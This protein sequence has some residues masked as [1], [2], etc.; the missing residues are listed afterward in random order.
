MASAKTQ[1]QIKY[2]NHSLSGHMA[3]TKMATGAVKKM[4]K[5]FILFALVFLGDEQPQSTKKK[6]IL[7]SATNIHL[8]RCNQR[9]DF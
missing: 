3:A 1:S 7:S 5:S 9:R 4:D 8:L 2:Q 6:T